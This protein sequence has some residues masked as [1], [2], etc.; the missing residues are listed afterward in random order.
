[1]VAV[2]TGVLELVPVFQH[3]LIGTAL[4]GLVGETIASRL[5]RRHPGARRRP[6]ALRWAWFGTGVALG[7][8]LLSG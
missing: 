6:V 4:G 2:I 1:M 5:E 3:T 8:H 7:V